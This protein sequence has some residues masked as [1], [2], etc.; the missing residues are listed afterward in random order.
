MCELSSVSEIISA[1][2]GIMTEEEQQRVIEV[3][4][5]KILILQ[6]RKTDTKKE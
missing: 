5:L 6:K 4:V 1:K 2:Y 3:T